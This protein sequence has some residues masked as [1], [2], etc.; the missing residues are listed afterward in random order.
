[1]QVLEAEG[2]EDVLLQAQEALAALQCK[3]HDCSH[4]AYVIH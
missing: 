4:N 1:M 3:V 2:M